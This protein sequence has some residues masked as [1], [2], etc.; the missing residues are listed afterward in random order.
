[1][2]LLRRVIS[3][4]GEKLTA[5]WTTAL[6]GVAREIVEAL[7]SLKPAAD[8]YTGADWQRT[9]KAKPVDAAMT[10]DLL[11]ALR[12]LDAA[13]LR[14]EAAGAIAANSSIFDPVAVVA[15]ALETLRSRERKGFGADAEAARLWKHAA[16]FL[17]DRSEFLPAPPT[18]WRQ[19]VT[20]S[21]ACEDCRELQKFVRDPLAQAARFKMAE[22][23]RRHLEGRIQHHGLDMS[24]MTERQG[25]PRTLVCTKTRRTYKRACE[26]HQADCA[27]MNIL[28]NVMPDGP[29]RDAKLP[30]RLAAAKALKPQI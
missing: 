20:I 25:S 13:T 9:Q 5:E 24:C 11:D 16:E 26:R 10:A 8:P 19:E 29:S 27:A 21:C 22:H 28:L 15:P 18:D 23:R 17:L 4:L 6:R 2:D 14:A 7:P 30:A 12:A 3:E 1:V